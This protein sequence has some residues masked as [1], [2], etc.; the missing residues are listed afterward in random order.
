MTV[1]LSM[2]VI[3]IITRLTSRIMFLEEEENRKEYIREVE[4][5]YQKIMKD[6]A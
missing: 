6:E 3:V 5:K 1:I 2:I 4:K